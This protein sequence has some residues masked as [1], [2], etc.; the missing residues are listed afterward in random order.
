MHVKPLS[1]MQRTVAFIGAASGWG[2]QYRE[3]EHGPQALF[4]AG[5]LEELIASDIVTIWAEHVH[6]IRRSSE[7]ALACGKPTLPLVAS[8]AQKLSNAVKRVLQKD[9][10]P[11][12]IGGDHA[13]AIGT[14]SAIV[15][16]LNMQQNFGLL[17]I[18]AHMDAHV[19]ETSP[20][21]AY[22]GMPVATLLGYGEE[23]LVTIENAYAK[24]DP[25]HVILMGIRSFEEGEAQLL[26]RLGV[27]IYFM[28]EI[29]QR[30]FKTVFNE[31][32]ETLR[33]LTPGFGISID[34]D[35]FDP[36]DAPGVGSPA[37]GGLI[38]KEVLETV[39]ALQVMPQFKALEI[40]EYNPAHDQEG[41]TA[42]LIISLLKEMLP[43]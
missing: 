27:K 3:T 33:N 9:Q 12:I 6:P 38:A 28:E 32:M 29:Q 43:R 14:W 35:A 24:L 21:H 4:D 18:D 11:V 31:A 34:I 8:H 23:K 20:S 1:Y 42:Q 17:W 5:L 22:H 40:T 26:Q 41:K 25:G 7:I 30:G 2:A 36:Q 15:T 19:P 37:A 10:F 39:H 13:V 16:S